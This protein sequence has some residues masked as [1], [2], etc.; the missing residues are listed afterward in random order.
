MPHVVTSLHL[1]VYTRLVSLP[2]V[3]IYKSPIKSDLVVYTFAQLC[4]ALNS[5]FFKPSDEIKTTRN[6]PSMH[7]IPN[8]RGSVRKI[9][10]FEFPVQRSQKLHF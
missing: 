1:Q 9:Q 7:T 10:D 5:E 3:Q 2:A 6:S 8:F 4:L